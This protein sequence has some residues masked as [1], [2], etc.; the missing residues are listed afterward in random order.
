MSSELESH[1]V[2]TPSQPDDTWTLTYPRGPLCAKAPNAAAPGEQ[3][4]QQ[5]PRAA[6]STKTSVAATTTTP[7]LTSG[8]PTPASTVGSAER[9]GVDGFAA[10]AV[11]LGRQIRSGVFRLLQQRLMSNSHQCYAVIPRFCGPSRRPIWPR[12]A[13]I[14]LWQRTM[15][16]MVYSRVIGVLRLGCSCASLLGQ[17][18]VST[19][20]GR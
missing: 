10:F 14:A 5:C 7:P 6:A 2:S 19:K 4:M 15:I 1:S 20:R 13:S 9:R 16:A 17:C 18:F 3:P 12:T 11:E 8:L